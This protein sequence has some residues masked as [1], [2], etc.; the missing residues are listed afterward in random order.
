MEVFEKI[1][2]YGDAF[3]S[4]MTDE[5][6]YQLRKDLI[7][8]VKYLI[9][10]RSNKQDTV[11]F[12]KYLKASPTERQERYSELNYPPIIAS[13]KKI[14]HPLYEVLN[15]D[16][17]FGYALNFLKT[18]LGFFNVMFENGLE[19]YSDELISYSLK[20]DIDEI[21]AGCHDLQP[22][23]RKEYFATWLR[24]S[25]EVC[26]FKEEEKEYRVKRKVESFLYQEIL[27]EEQREYFESATMTSKEDS[28]PILSEFAKTDEI[29]FNV[30][31]ENLT[32]ERL[33][34]FNQKPTTYKST[35]LYDSRANKD[36]FCKCVAGWIKP[37]I[38]GK[39][40][41]DDN[42]TRRLQ[43]NV[44]RLFDDFMKRV[45]DE[46]SNC[47]FPL[48]ILAFGWARE[49]TQLIKLTVENFIG[50]S[51]YPLSY[52]ALIMCLQAEACCQEYIENFTQDFW[53]IHDDVLYNFWGEEYTQNIK[54]LKSRGI[55]YS[56]TPELTSYDYNKSRLHSE[57]DKRLKSIE[58]LSQKSLDYQLEIF[59]F[60]S[61][62][63]HLFDDYITRVYENSSR[64]LFDLNLSV[65]HWMNV[66][67]GF[68]LTKINFN[69]Y[70]CLDS[71][72]RRN[73]TKF[74]GCT[75]K[76]S[77]CD[78]YHDFITQVIGQFDLMYK[79]A[80]DKINCYFQE[81][82]QKQSQNLDK[83][84]DVI[85]PIPVDAERASQ[86]LTMGQGKS[87]GINSEASCSDTSHQESNRK[88]GLKKGKP[89]IKFRDC[90]I[91]S[92]DAD[93]LII[94]FHSMLDGKTGNTAY[95]ILFAAKAGGLITKPSYN[96]IVEEFKISGSSSGYDSYMGKCS[97]SEDE[98]A[99]IVSRIKEEMAKL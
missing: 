74:Y 39:N 14:R 6:I 79:K 81:E 22:S 54:E 37:C 33:R 75:P 11:R 38:E 40:F 51:K 87:L 10:I 72:E 56:G 20:F 98:I 3:H 57:V 62:I 12:C 60:F 23:K 34:C 17:S 95:S 7:V 19:A 28:F 84:S 49:A 86:N 61:W 4:E 67:E 63:E 76:D 65:N 1:D 31:L 82:Q 27:K 90:I 48:Q 13:W 46:F 53:K 47:F 18:N 2:E 25:K 8:I 15:W 59:K 71:Q 24:Q 92:A 89:R 44:K 68:V 85:R 5:Q 77:L 36:Y 97:L 80:L 16:Y 45:E 99:P 26:N 30:W 35:P 78:F 41:C 21:V 29:L 88:A 69:L 73:D 96:S 91:S 83:E 52:P 70:E 58:T 9:P 93:K 94:V 50:E 43:N 55:Y 32:N 64:D 42:L 66:T